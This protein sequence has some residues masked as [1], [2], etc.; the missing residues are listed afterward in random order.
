M[1]K[2]SNAYNKFSLLNLK[3][4]TIFEMKRLL[5][6]PLKIVIYFLV[7]I[8][9]SFGAKAVLGGE[10]AKLNIA[11]VDED[12]S[13]D[14]AVLLSNFEQSKVAG[15]ANIYYLDMYEAREKLA[16]GK[17]IAV[18]YI[19]ADTT[20]N[21]YDGVLTDIEV[22]IRKK[23]VKTRY[24]LEYIDRMIGLFNTSQ[25]Q[26]MYYLD[27]MLD[28]DGMTRDEVFD[29]FY[30]ISN[31]IFFAFMTRG[32]VINEQNGVDIDYLGEL[33]NVFT[34]IFVLFGV[35]FSYFN[36]Y[37]DLFSGK[38][39]RLLSFGY[40]SLEYS[41]SKLITATGINL[42]SLT[43]ILSI[44]KIFFGDSSTVLGFSSLATLVLLGIF[45]SLFYEVFARISFMGG[46]LPI[47][48]MVAITLFSTLFKLNN[49]LPS[50]WSKLIGLNFVSV[51]VNILKGYDLGLQG[52]GLLLMW[53]GI[54]LILLGR[55]R[56]LKR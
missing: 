25:T 54:F 12:G 19:P 27:V 37:D 24:L 36:Y 11:V 55:K 15:A 41:L 23:D 56:R 3:R 26:A 9:L 13:E 33:I 18:F 48:S 50:I 2:S 16:E 1:K 22:F 5:G 17:L 44:L 53:F 38:K 49:Y 8:L 28:D 47:L 10:E 31:A 7:F 34:V 21:I 42:I 45:L 43:L 52:L 29:K 35:S 32:S 51:F 4:L 30:D 14:V 40:S 6:N 20:S 46:Y 39:A